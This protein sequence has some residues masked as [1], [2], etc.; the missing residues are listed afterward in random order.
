MRNQIFGT[1]WRLFLGTIILVIV[2]LSNANGQSNR[3]AY[4]DARS[5]VL[6]LDKN[7]PLGHIYSLDLSKETFGSEKEAKHF[8]RKYNSALISCAVHFD[9]KRV[10]IRLD[11]RSRPKWE[12]ADWN[13][14]LAST[15]RNKINN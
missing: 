14:L 5:K 10:N 8:F 2:S 1:G 11:L 7:A 9:E 12:V 6:S 15:A 3:S 4:L 13:A